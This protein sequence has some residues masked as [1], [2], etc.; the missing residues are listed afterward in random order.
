MK[1]Y[2]QVVEECR[3]ELLPR[4][5]SNAS[6]EHAYVLFDNLLELSL[7]KN[8]SVKIVTGCLEQPFYEQLENKIKAILEKG[9]GIDII[10]LC[11]KEKLSH[12]SIAKIVSEHK[13]GSVKV[14]K[15]DGE[16]HQQH[17]ILVGDRSYRIEFSNK[18]KIA[19]AN[20][21]NELVGEFLQKQFAELSHKEDLFISYQN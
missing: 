19:E 21:N 4:R 3:K 7:D 16:Y 20:F 1:D 11:T 17:F 18:N 6:I 14:L 10:S 15:A 8:L 12:N 2:L 9:I 5:I 13:N